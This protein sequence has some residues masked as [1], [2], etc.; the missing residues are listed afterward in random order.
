M[1]WCLKRVMI[2]TKQLEASHME[3][4]AT[5]VGEEFNSGCLGVGPVGSAAGFP[6]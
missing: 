5:R 2:C 4:A 6:S 3:D 1:L